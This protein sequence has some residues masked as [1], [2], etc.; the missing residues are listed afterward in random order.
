VRRFWKSVVHPLL[1][2][3]QPETILEIGAAGGKHTRLLAEYC[4]QTRATLH[5]IEPEPRFDT[6]AL[7]RDGVV[8]HRDLSLN[9]LPSLPAVDV[10]LVD[11]DHNWYTVVNELRQLQR[12]AREGRRPMPV[13][14]CHDVAWPYGRRD[15]YY[16][17][18]TIPDEFR[19]PWAEKG[20]VE[21]QSEL[22]PEG[23]Q[24]PLSANAC[25][26]GGPRNGVLT[27]IEDFLGE[28]GEEISIRVTPDNYGLAILVPKT[29]S[30]DGE[31]EAT[32]ERLLA[33]GP[34]PKAA[35]RAQATAAQEIPKVI[36]HVWLGS[37]PVS[38]QLELYAATWRAHHP[39]WEVRL[40]RDDTLPP[41]ALGDVIDEL[42]DERWTKGRALTSADRARI[43]WRARYDIV[44]LEVLRQFGGVIVDMDVEAIRPLDPLLGGVTAFAGRTRDSLLRVGN[45]VLGATPEHPFLEYAT[46]RIRELAEVAENANRLAGHSFLSS[47]VNARPEGV[48]IF[49]RETFYS[50]L[51][52]AAPKRPDRFP[53]I[54]A[55]HHHLE[56]YLGPQAEAARLQRRL[57]EAQGEL[58]RVYRRQNR[59]K[60]ENT[61]LR[62]RLERA[63]QQVEQLTQKLARLRENSAES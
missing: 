43:T 28:A 9:V 55:V 21:G 25:V 12:A 1:D 5:V 36:H 48:T 24:N 52:I 38:E 3:V 6:E 31:L 11:G 7:P 32:V 63:E 62:S 60:T 15:L 35:A 44:R 29:R 47:A 8:L 14:L 54:Y 13:V 45:Q 37:D 46:T 22:V 34:K 20:M 51:T 50:L 19:Q 30:P 41:L 2:A 17:P 61:R 39:E 16:F 10:A 40:W 27:A 59:A 33:A 42:D 49:P 26:E 4:S 23:G 56:S 57:G 58:E 53:Q 18:E